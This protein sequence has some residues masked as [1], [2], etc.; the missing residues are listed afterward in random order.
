MDRRR[1]NQL[2]G[3]GSNITLQTTVLWL[4][5]REECGFHLTTSD[6][7]ADPLSRRRLLSTFFSNPNLLRVADIGYLAFQP[8]MEL[9]SIDVKDI[10][11]FIKL[12]S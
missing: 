11:S 9:S 5:T 1:T 6:A 4:D 12:S 10:V 8:L 3:L 7:V 2:L